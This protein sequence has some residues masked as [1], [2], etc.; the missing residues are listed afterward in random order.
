M[1]FINWKRWLLKGLLI[2]AIFLID[3]IKDINAKMEKLETAG[4][5]ALSNGKLY[6]LKFEN[7]CDSPGKYKSELIKHAKNYRNFE[8]KN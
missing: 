5:Y 4:Y 6:F 2:F 1:T 8:L 3:D 7:T